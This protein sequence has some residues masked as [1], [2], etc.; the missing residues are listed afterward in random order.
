MNGLN[1]ARR[2]KS[3]NKRREMTATEAIAFDIAANEGLTQKDLCQPHYTADAEAYMN[4]FY[5][6]E[7]YGYKRDDIRVNLGTNRRH[8]SSAAIARLAA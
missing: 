8:I 5:D 1:A 6:R 4:G 2:V 7:I 3:Q